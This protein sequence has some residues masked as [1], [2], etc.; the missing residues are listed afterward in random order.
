M[1][2]NLRG[3][4]TALNSTFPVIWQRALRSAFGYNPSSYKRT[5]QAIAASTSFVDAADLTIELDPGRYQLRYVL[6]TPSMTAAGNLK[7]QL[8]G[9]DGLVVNT[10]RLAATFLLTGVA[11][12][13]GVATALSSALN[14]GTTNAWTEV[15]VDVTIDIGQQGKLALQV[16]QQAASGSTTIDAGSCV[17]ATQLTFLS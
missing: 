12:A 14:G 10:V 13:H 7:L 5:S 16:A 15:T 6:Y 17:T 1:A 11:P 8:V 9:Q 2:L 3:F 4:T